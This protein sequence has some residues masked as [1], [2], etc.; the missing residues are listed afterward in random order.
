MTEFL[1]MLG[2][3]MTRL[4]RRQHMLLPGSVTQTE[5]AR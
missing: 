3:V 5:V 2:V 4:D 1:H